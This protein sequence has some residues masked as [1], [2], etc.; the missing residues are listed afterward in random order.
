MGGLGAAHIPQAFPHL[1]FHVIER[2]PDTCPPPPTNVTVYE[3][4]WYDLATWPQVPSDGWRAAVMDLGNPSGGE[5]LVQLHRQ[6]AGEGLRQKLGDAPLLS[7]T[8]LAAT[9]PMSAIWRF[10]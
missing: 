4:D 8:Y 1:H 9:V 2:S 5:K 7:L 10:T 6:G 3:G